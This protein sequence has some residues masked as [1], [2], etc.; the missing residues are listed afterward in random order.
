MLSFKFKLKVTCAVGWSPA[1][2][3]ACSQYCICV[4]IYICIFH[5]NTCIV[6]QTCLHKAIYLYPC[7]HKFRKLFWSSW[8]SWSQ[9][10]EKFPSAT[11]LRFIVFAHVEQVAN[12]LLC[13]KMQ[14]NA[15]FQVL[16]AV[17]ARGYAQV[18]ISIHTY[19]HIYIH[20]LLAPLR[21]Y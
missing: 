11:S 5:A 3:H 21:E 17:L 19:V 18:V 10:G 6:K 8:G 12:I 7:F 13:I 15:L 9:V 14:C 2:I 1:W 20:I 16:S 4:Y